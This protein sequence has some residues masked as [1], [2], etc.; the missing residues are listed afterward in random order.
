MQ[1]RNMK[2]IRVF[3]GKVSVLKENFSIHLNRC[4]FVMRQRDATSVAALFASVLN[5]PVHV[6][7]IRVTFYQQHFDVTATRIARLY[8]TVTWNASNT[9]FDY[10]GQ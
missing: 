7:Q 9:R 3:I 8:S 10:I 1:S 4:V 6:S 2:N 5:A